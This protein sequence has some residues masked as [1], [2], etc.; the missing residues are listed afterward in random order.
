M[1]PEVSVERIRVA[2]GCAREPRGLACA[3]VAKL[4]E[5]VPSREARAAQG[6]VVGGL[7]QAPLRLQRKHTVVVVVVAMEQTRAP[8]SFGVSIVWIGVPKYTKD[9]GTKKQKGRQIIIP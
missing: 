5:R 6:D 8:D 1:L 7:V 4:Y 9:I 3:V 2:A